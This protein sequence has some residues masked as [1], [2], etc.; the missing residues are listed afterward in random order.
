MYHAVG[1]EKKHT[2]RH[3]G[4]D[5]SDT[6]NRRSGVLIADKEQSVTH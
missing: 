3:F 4:T 6:D 2:Q 1:A 5:P